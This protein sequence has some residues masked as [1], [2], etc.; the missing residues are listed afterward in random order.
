MPGTIT[1]QVIVFRKAIEDIRATIGREAATPALQR[2]P[3]MRRLSSSAILTSVAIVIA[4]AMI[5]GSI[6][7]TSHLQMV[8]AAAVASDAS[9]AAEPQAPPADIAKVDLKGAPFIGQEDAPVVMAYWFD[10]QCPFCKKEEESVFPQLVKDYVDAG[11]L[12]VVFKD[13]AFLGPQ[14]VTAGLA[15]RAVWQVAPEKFGVWHTAMFDHQDEENA[16][17]GSKDDILALTKSIDGIDVAKVEDLMTSKEADFKS[18]IQADT[19]EGYS[20]GVGGTPSF[21]VGKTMMVGAQPYE[22]LKAA[23]DAELKTVKAPTG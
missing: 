12:K 16:G 15:A 22:A 4:G 19:S 10:Y 14:S 18:A 3:V 1:R 8:Q 2:F 5:S 13:F 11:K 20:M 23:I 7:W 9:A 17:W 6:V 21:L